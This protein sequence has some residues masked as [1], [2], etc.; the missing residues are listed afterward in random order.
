MARKH[1]RLVKGKCLECGEQI[2]RAR[3]T[4]F[5]DP[6][7]SVVFWRKA[8]QTKRIEA[9]LQ[10]GRWP[11]R[12]LIERFMLFVEKKDGCWLWKGKL[13][14]RDHDYGY[15]RISNGRT[16]VR[17]IL[18]HRWAYEYYKGPIPSGLSIDHLC[19]VRNCV[20]P[21]HL[22]AVTTAEN[23]RRSVARGRHR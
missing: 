20:N 18:S 10:L 6:K 3:S 16:G 8:S 13:H 4:K 19:S 2:V 21:E 17:D 7:C 11:K 5:C 22:E 15:F 1:K 12:T 9:G 14:G 23:N